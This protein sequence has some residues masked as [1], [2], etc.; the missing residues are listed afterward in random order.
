[1]QQDIDHLTVLI[2]WVAEK[3]VTYNVS[4]EPETIAENVTTSSIQIKVSYSTSYNVS[5]EA[6]LCGQM[7]VEIYYGEFL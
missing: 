7:N 6:T 3:R 4:I 5:V 1:M 2:K